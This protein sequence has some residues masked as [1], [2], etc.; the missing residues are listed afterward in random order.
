MGKKPTSLCKTMKTCLQKEHRATRGGIKA[1]RLVENLEAKT[2]SPKGTSEHILPT[3]LSS[4]SLE[5][6]KSLEQDQQEKN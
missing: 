6:F 2:V 1:T 3:A 4:L 5:D